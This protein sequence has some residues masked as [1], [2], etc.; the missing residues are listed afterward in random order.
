MVGARVACPRRRRVRAGF[1]SGVSGRALDGNASDVTEHSDAAILHTAISGWTAGLFRHDT[2]ELALARALLGVLEDELAHGVHTHELAV[3]HH[4]LLPV[5]ERLRD[6]QL[7]RARRQRGAVA[8]LSEREYEVLEL[9]AAGRT[10]N[11]I[12]CGLFVSPVTVRTHV[13]AIKHKLGTP[14]RTAAV[15]LLEEI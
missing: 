5:I 11:E 15:L 6:E 4:L 2:D 1:R 7:Q 13:G 12:A 10:T 3:P 14:T 8:N 9:L